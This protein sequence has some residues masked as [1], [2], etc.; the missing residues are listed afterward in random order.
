MDKE[1]IE[2]L[3]READ[4]KYFA[5]HSDHTK[6]DYEGHLS[7]TAD[8]LVKHLK[9][10]NNGKDHSKSTPTGGHKSQRQSSSAGAKTKK[11][12]QVPRLRLTH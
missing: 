9:G 3:L 5:S 4:N 6:Y 8:Y 7:F 11:S 12:V 1:I 2:K 10:G